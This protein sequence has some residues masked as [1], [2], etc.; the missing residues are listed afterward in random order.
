MIALLR[1]EVTINVVQSAPG[2]QTY[3]TINLCVGQ[4]VFLEAAEG[5]SYLWSPADLVTNPLVQNPYT[6]PSSNTTYYV[7]IANACGV[8]VDSVSIELIAPTASATGGGWMCR[9][10]T[11]ELSASDA[12][13][14]SWAPAGLVANP[15]AQMTSVFPVETTTFTV[16]A[17]D[18]FGCTGS[19]EI[20]VQVWQPPY[21]DAG[22]D[23][24]VDWLDEVRLFG[25]VDADTLWWTPSENLS[26]SDCLSPEVTVTGPGWF[27]LET[28]SPEGC[29]ARDS[30][31]IDVFNPVFVPNTFTPN[32]DGVNDAFFVEGIE[33]RGYRLE[34]FNR[35]G[36]LIFY[37]ENSAEPWI[38][39]HQVRDSEYFVPDGVYIWRLRYEL[40]DGPRLVEGTV[41]IVR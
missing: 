36:D 17:T 25:T 32:N 37:S 8:G 24:E 4:G 5:V 20:T 7:S 26:C 19:T 18:E 14:Y 1:K 2:G 31:Y 34:V 12:V 10:E 30:T 41:A 29:I 38:G 40:R 27:V 13:S 11:M 3:P 22:P 6:S 35:W 9:G 15:N 21:V 28:I 33:P 23:R 39:N 16:Y